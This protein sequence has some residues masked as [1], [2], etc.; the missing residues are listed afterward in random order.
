V[1]VATVVAYLPGARDGW[2]WAV[3]DVRAMARGD[4]SMAEATAPWLQIGDLVANMHLAL[5][6]RGPATDADAGRWLAGAWTELD[7]ALA[8][9]DGPEGARLHE[10]AA[11]LRAMIDRLGQAGGT[12]VQD[13]H[14][15]LHVGQMLRWHAAGSAASLPR[16]QSPSRDDMWTLAHQTRRATG[17]SESTRRG[18]PSYAVTD[19]DG[20]PVLSPTD[21]AAAGPAA[22]DVAGLLQSLDHVGRV[23]SHRTD[24]VPSALIDEWI[25]AAQ[26]AVLDAYRAALAA[27][28]RPH[29]LDESLLPA[30]R[31]RQVV[32]EYLY[33]VRHLPH[34][35]YV[36]HSALPSLVA[37]AQNAWPAGP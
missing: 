12:A 4:L 10:H 21:R 37:G 22:V 1:L 9:V 7:D 25:A 26:G 18:G 36:P 17:V 35:R 11:T 2:D 19:F 30:L 31:A 33:A 15:D 23:V 16:P 24:H 28:H 3:E 13:I 6:E 32:R 5:P 29:L 14:G 8:I 34:W 27:A 20:N